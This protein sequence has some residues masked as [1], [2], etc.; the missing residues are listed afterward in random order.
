MKNM[1]YG[2]AAILI[3]AGC[4]SSKHTGNGQSENSLYQTWDLAWLKGDSVKVDLER[5]VFIE[6]DQNTKRVAGS[7]GCNR[8]FST[9]SNDKNNLTIKP[10]ASTK[11]ACADESKS[12]LENDFFQT[13]EEVTS[14]KSENGQLTLFRNNT[15]V[16]AFTESNV[17]PNDLA[18]HWELFYITG[19]RITFEGLYPDKKPN[20]TFKSGQIEFSGFTSCNGMSAKFQN[21][22]KGNLFRPGVMTMMAC[23]GNG[24]Q[25]FL[26][27]FNR[28]DDYKVTGDTL[29]M[30]HDKIPTMKFVKKEMPSNQ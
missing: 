27:E 7:G 26:K 14:Y 10:V 21:K 13:L 5:P 12:K 28:V 3:M 20:L 18:G 19:P 25:T 23:P 1:A 16:A 15:P 4:T 30:F 8:F 29:T 22:K 11:M 17:I 2:I 24:E 9:F 6:F